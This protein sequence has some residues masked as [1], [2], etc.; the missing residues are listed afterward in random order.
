MRSLAVAVLAAMAMSVAVQSV[1]AESAAS[2]GQSEVKV[3]KLLKAQ[4]I[5]GKSVLKSNDSR[6]PQ[7]V[8]YFDHE[9][10]MQNLPKEVRSFLSSYDE[11]VRRI[12]EGVSADEVLMMDGTGTNTVVGPVLGDIE[13]NQDAPYNNKC[14]YINGGRALTGC[15]ATA[16]SQIMTFYQYPAVGTGTT[17]Y[18]GSSGE[19]TYNFADH[20]FN[21]SN[22]LHQYK[23]VY[24]NAQ[25]DAVAELMLA[26]GASVKMNYNT[27]GSGAN[28]E[29]VAPALRDYFGYDSQIA[30]A[31]PDP[32]QETQ[33]TIW[34]TR[35]RRE[36]DANRPVYYSGGTQT[37]GH[38]FVIDGYKEE[39]GVTYF[40]VNWGWSGAYN[41]Y[42]LLTGLRPKS[43]ES[44]YS[45]R[46][47]CV[48]NIFPLGSGI[49][50]TKES[51]TWKVDM[52]AP[53]YT[54][55]GTK[56]PATNMQR[57]MIYIQN[58]RKFVW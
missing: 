52:D 12:D 43:T 31:Q 16:M 36:F 5:N 6:L 29:K 18:T 41:G 37:D 7:V 25:G 15:V 19:A 42:F 34:T 30:Y 13:F 58:G 28:S 39:N 56:I 45:Y 35:L 24:T 57:G 20:P 32:S 38:A 27:D 48:Y 22:I 4:K 53:V 33:Y 8:A 17:T 54:V 47:Q 55:L 11:A 9:V 44:G 10:D 49:E 21:W 46:N 40:H 14:P 3:N 51:G 26:C 50:N 2:K 1:S 23:G